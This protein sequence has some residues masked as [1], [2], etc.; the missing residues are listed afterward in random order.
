VW[1]CG[2]EVRSGEANEARLWSCSCWA[3]A[4]LGF[5]A[6]TI[7]VGL[8]FTERRS[9][10]NGGDAAALAGASALQLF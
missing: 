3:L 5:T 7:D 2:V 1:A 6:L 4:V 10:Q 8:F 9:A